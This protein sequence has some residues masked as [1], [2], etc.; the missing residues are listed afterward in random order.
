MFSTGDERDPVVEYKTYREKQLENM[1]DTS[2]T[3]HT[4]ISVTETTKK[5]WKRIRIEESDSD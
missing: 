3:I 1:M 2:Q 4:R 5:R